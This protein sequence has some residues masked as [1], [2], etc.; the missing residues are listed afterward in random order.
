VYGQEMQST[1]ETDL[2][3]FNPIHTEKNEYIFFQIFS[4]SRKAFRDLK[5]LRI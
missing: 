2:T 1:R 4:I 5:F 3:L